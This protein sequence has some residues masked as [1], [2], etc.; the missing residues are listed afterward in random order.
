MDKT[1]NKEYSEALKEMKK[2]RKTVDPLVALL[3]VDHYGQELLETIIPKLP[4]DVIERIDIRF[5]L[6]YQLL[7]NQIRR[8]EMP[9]DQDL[10][11]DSSDNKY[12]DFKTVCKIL[13]RKRATVESLISKGDIKPVADKSGRKRRFDKSKIYEYIERLNNLRNNKE[14][15]LHK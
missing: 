11:S 10:S 15:G 9:D 3:L 1:V 8:I 6:I 7:N 14:T 12:C 13:D 2:F 5:H 4:V